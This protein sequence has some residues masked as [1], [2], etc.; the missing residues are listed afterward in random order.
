MSTHPA[1]PPRSTAVQPLGCLLLVG[2][3][4]TILGVLV[5]A[6]SRQEAARV[7][8][9]P[10]IGQVR[11]VNA[12]CT[13]TIYRDAADYDAFI[14]AWNDRQAFRD[15]APMTL[16]NAAVAAGRAWVPSPGTRVRIDDRRNG[17]PTVQIVDGIHAGHVGRLFGERC[18]GR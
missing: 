9:D 6:A 18:L 15:G 7:A 4:V 8:A 5:W 11:T 2:V 13:I 1:P 3:S 16:R 12:D 14:S 17:V 10:L